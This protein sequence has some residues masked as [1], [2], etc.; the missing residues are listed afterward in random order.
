MQGNEAIDEKSCHVNFTAEERNPIFSD[1][2]LKDN[3]AIP[4]LEQV[5]YL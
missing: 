3:N 1:A 4:L 2:S 5:Q